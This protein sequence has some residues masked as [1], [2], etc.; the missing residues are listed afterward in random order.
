[1]TFYL[2]IFPLYSGICN[3]FLS[4]FLPTPSHSKLLL[5][6][7]VPFC[8]LFLGH[9]LCCF[10]F[11]TFCLAHLFFFYLT[12]PTPHHQWYL[13]SLSLPSICASVPAPPTAASPA[14]LSLYE[15]MYVCVCVC[16]YIYIYLFIYLFI[17]SCFST[18]KV[19]ATH[20]TKPLLLT[21]HSVIA[22]WPSR[23]IVHSCCCK[24]LISHFSNILVG[25]CGM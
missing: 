17:L 23:Q 15:C 1:M 20:F 9:H 18:V 14:V 3:F 19:E 2:I 25:L 10:Y 21:F 5:Y 16:V 24:K 12:I 11:F 22:S 7:L 4:R 6:L 8:L 13:T